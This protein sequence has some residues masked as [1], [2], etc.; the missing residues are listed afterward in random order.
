MSGAEA[1]DRRGALVSISG[2]WEKQRVE[3]FERL[4]SIARRSFVGS[5]L[6]RA[7]DLGSGGRPLSERITASPSFSN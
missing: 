6:T 3:T 7:A 5:I 4:G 2:N 1:S